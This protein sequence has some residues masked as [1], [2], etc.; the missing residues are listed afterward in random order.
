MI[1]TAEEGVRIGIE[2][3]YDSEEEGEDLIEKDSDVM[4]IA[5]K[6]RKVRLILTAP[7]S[8]PTATSLLLSQAQERGDF[9]SR[10]IPAVATIPVTEI[11]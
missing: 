1:L 7:T 10:C 11:Q 2:V 9:D 4:S 8:L 5:K 3:V 6:A